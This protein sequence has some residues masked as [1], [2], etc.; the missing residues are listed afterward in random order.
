MSSFK[1]PEWLGK[2]HG[3]FST[4]APDL[5]YSVVMDAWFDQNR[6]PPSSLWDTHHSALIGDPNA[7]EA[8]REFY[9]ALI[10]SRLT[11]T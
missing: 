8:M 1:P 3:D 11:Q 5:P 10:T 4:Y 7:L 2:P 9:T 6:W